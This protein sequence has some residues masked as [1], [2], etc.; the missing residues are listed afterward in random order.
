MTPSLAHLLIVP[1]VWPLIAA[2]LMLPLGAQRRGITSAVNVG[3]TLV[4]LIVAIAL[5][6]Q[7]DAGGDGGTIAVYLAANWEAPFGIVLVA[8]RLTALMLVL[9]SV[10]GLG[11]AIYSMGTWGRAGVYF[12]PL[13]QI[14]LMG[15]NGAFLTGDLFNL[16]VFFE[17]ALAASYGLQLHGSGS[18][19]VKAGLHYI[20]INLLASALFLIG[21]AVVYGVMGTLTMADVAARMSL[22]AEADRGLLH[23]GA[24]M[25][26]TA[27][28]VKAGMWPMNFW[29]VPAYQT[30]SAPV[31]ALFALMT[32]LGVYALLRLWT[33]CF[34]AEA[35]PS[36]GVGAELFLLGG[37]ATLAFGIVG[38]A[39]TAQ[40]G[41]V[42]GFSIIVSSGTL[43]A[44]MGL[45]EVGATAGV[46][47]YLMSATV[48][49]SALFLLVEL[50]ERTGTGRL[51]PEPDHDLDLDADEDTNLDDDELP[52]VGRRFP[53]SLALLGA[54]FA[55]S[56]LLV[57]GL[58]PLSGFI[59][60]VALLAPVLR[61]ATH[62]GS[63]AP[64]LEAWA[65]FAA[66]LIGG[67]VS[68]VVLAKAGVRHFW[69]SAEGAQPVVKFAEGLPILL[70]LVIGVGLTIRAEDGLRYAEA[71]ARSLQEPAS[72]IRAVSGMAP[73]PGPTRAAPAAG[74][75]ATP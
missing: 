64:V 1:V 7:V 39:S 65:L 52:L 41:R 25:L 61:A 13:F 38:L 43:L 2:M 50:V 73:V 75:G 69:R 57:A 22:V 9:T 46:L 18:A 30:A 14:L 67:L 4:G 32:K 66:L 48:A 53:G 31:A 54:G 11:S 72:Y 45:G 60:K 26:A 74:T 49:A 56:A 27:F 55:L 58:P 10:V 62:G 28:L 8:D 17:V 44:T 42:A 24:A 34:S 59:A 15:L 5:L 33:L 23:V 37:L 20:V 71:T 40:L 35:G 47:Y 63:G 29:L 36:A 12:H 16:F 3:A 21:L 70:L 19:R 68:T 51:V 6:N